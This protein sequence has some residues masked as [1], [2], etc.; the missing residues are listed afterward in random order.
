MYHFVLT[1]DTNNDIMIAEKATVTMPAHRYMR[2]EDVEISGGKE[3]YVY[4]DG[5]VAIVEFSHN[6]QGGVI[7]IH[8]DNGVPQYIFGRDGISW[9]QDYLSNSTKRS[10]K[11][12][13]EKY[14][15]VDI[16]IK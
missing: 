7:K 16:P 11:K 2:C 1:F 3:C 8:Y 5:S 6:A 9:R 15:G 13:M 10:I 4:R 12:I 14:W